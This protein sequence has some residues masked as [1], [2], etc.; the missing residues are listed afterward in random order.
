MVVGGLGAGLGSGL[1]PSC[2]E[3]EASEALEGFPNSSALGPASYTHRAEGALNLRPCPPS[4]FSSPVCAEF[5]PHP[6]GKLPPQAKVT[7]FTL[8]GPVVLG[9]S[10][11]T[12]AAS[13]ASFPA[14]G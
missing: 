9:Q 13:Q 12:L 4:C 8:P 2:G 7:A 1:R 6:P 10:T 3:K 14:L 5:H 11:P